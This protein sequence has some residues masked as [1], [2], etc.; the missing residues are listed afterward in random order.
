MPIRYKNGSPVKDSSNVFHER[1]KS[2]KIVSVY[3]SASESELLDSMRGKTSRTEFFRAL[4]L[5]E[6]RME[7]VLE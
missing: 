2:K 4:L 3:L 5:A 1:W 6:A 7:G